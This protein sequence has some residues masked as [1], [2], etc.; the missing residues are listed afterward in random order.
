MG[1]QSGLVV[2]EM[3]NPKGVRWAKRTFALGKLFGNNE[4]ELRLES[5][6]ESGQVVV[7]LR[8]HQVHKGVVGMV[9]NPKLGVF[10]QHRLSAVRHVSISRGC[11][12]TYLAYCCLR[13][14]VFLGQTLQLSDETS[15]YQCPQ[16]LAGFNIVHLVAELYVVS[17]K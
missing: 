8:P 13:A 11:N 2:S 7:Q 3:E 16:T 1:V 17:M 6:D 12:S 5:W 4:F 9:P 10:A 14:Q 15:R